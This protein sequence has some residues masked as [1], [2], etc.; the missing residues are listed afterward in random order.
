MAETLYIPALRFHWLT[1][2]YDWLIRSF[3][4]EKKFKSALLQQASLAN[5]QKILDFGTG[6][7]TLSIM[8]KRLY[9]EAE[10]TGIDVDPRILSLANKKIQREKVAIELS[11]YN[12]DFLPFPDGKFDRVISS[13]VFHHLT[14]D[15]KNRSLSEIYRVLKTGGE[16]HIADWGKPANFMMRAV[17]FFEQYFDGYERTIDSVRGLLPQIIKEAGFTE[18]KETIFF[19]TVLGTVSLYKAR[20]SGFS[21]G[22]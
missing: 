3:L 2:Y 18:V 8:A 17:F 16:L 21:S 5:G 6:T 19:N 4:P 15:Q 20:K 22:K 1:D 13:L 12:G 9:P 10:I 14:R 11:G 7:A